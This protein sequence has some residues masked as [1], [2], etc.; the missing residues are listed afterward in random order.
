M[1]IGIQAFITGFARAFALTD[2]STGRTI[3][4][5][6]GPKG[7]E[8]S[9]SRNL[10]R[11][12][13]A[14]DSVSLII[15]THAHSDHSAPLPHLKQVTGA[16]LMCSRQAAEA[17]SDGRDEE[18]IPRNRTGRFIMLMSKSIPAKSHSLIIPDL[19]VENETDL[20]PFGINAVAILTPGH[21]AGSLSVLTADGDAIIGDL[22]MKFIPGRP[23]LSFLSNDLRALTD[24]L[25]LL[26][27]RG[28][29]SFHLA[30]GG[31]IDRKTVKTI[32]E[33]ENTGR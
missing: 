25:Q 21:T 29:R 26:L 20:K 8:I 22:L 19:I 16:P 18:I 10:S 27:H 17:L 1:S 3:L 33:R 32:L 15:L 24:S 14:A 4:V 2:D 31:T 11:I 28:A 13:I 7:D 6:A 5:D 23:G 12:G 30:H 9:L